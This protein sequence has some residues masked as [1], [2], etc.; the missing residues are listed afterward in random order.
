MD[1][2]ASTLTPQ[3]LRRVGRLGLVCALAVALPGCS[4]KKMAINSL[5][6]A[7]AEGTSTFATDDD[8]EL[9]RDAVPFALKTIETL[10]V[11]SPKH[12]GLLQAACSGF[13]QYG[14]AFVQHE[15][16]FVESQD[17]DRATAMRARARKLYLRALDYGLR[18][19][20]VDYPGLR[21]GLDNVG[22]LLFE[23]HDRTGLHHLPQN[24]DQPCPILFDRD[25]DLRIDEVILAEP[26][27]Q[28]I[29]HL[30]GGVSHHLHFAEQRIADRSAGL[31]ASFHTE[32]LLVEDFDDQK[33]RSLDASIRHVLCGAAGDH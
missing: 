33:I 9:V 13:T 5:G 32:V 11:E 23:E 12:R 6:S 20:E 28:F 21:D 30:L 22:L 17:L 1:C 15:A 24:R 29:R 16:D 10:I 4:I 26:L 2:L 8:P 27:L 18:G 3:L 19:L 14:Y 31:D 7:L 25:A